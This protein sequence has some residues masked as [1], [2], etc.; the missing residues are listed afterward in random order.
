MDEDRVLQSL[1]RLEQGQQEHRAETQRLQQVQQE[2]RHETHR[3]QQAQ[4]EHRADTQRVKQAQQEHRAETHRLQQAQQEHR[5]DTQRMEQAQQEHRA[6]THRLQQ[7]QQEHRAETQRLERGQQEHRRE[8]LEFRTTVM[9]KF[10][11]LEDKLERLSASLAM[12]VEQVGG[13]LDQL[14]AREAQLALLQDAIRSGINAESLQVRTVQRTLASM[15]GLV[16]TLQSQL[17]D[18]TQRVDEM[19]PLPRQSPAQGQ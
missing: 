5:A 17:G 14:T 16:L 11:R 19:Q 1:D 3:L 10:E 6:E 15:S 4:E 8:T 13:I 7:A 12:N 18:L 2:H 9:G